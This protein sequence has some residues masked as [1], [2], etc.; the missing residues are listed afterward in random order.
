MASDM[1]ITDDNR[2]WAGKKLTKVALQPRYIIGSCGDATKSS[3]FEDWFFKSYKSDD[4]F[5]E[6][7]FEWKGT[8]SM[9]LFDNGNLFLFDEGS[10]M[11][12]FEPFFAIGTGGDY[13]LGALYAG[14]GPSESIKIASGLDPNTGLGVQL[15]T[16]SDS[17]NQ[18]DSV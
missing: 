17:D 4:I 1:Q 7:K 5:K 18:Y 9:I 11:Q 3:N 13:A 15:E 12:I 10:P 16:L 2:K 6:Q 8:K 14:A